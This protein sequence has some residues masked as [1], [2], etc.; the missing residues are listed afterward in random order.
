MSSI[1][2]NMIAPNP[3][4]GT[5]GPLEHAVRLK[6]ISAAKDHFAKHGYSKASVADIAR[7]AGFSKA[8]VYKFFDSKEAVGQALAAHI[9]VDYLGRAR[10]ASSRGP[11]AM[12]R[13]RLLL[14]EMIA[15]MRELCADGSRLYEIVF[16]S[17]EHR[18]APS[19]AYLGGLEEIARTIVMAGRT[20]GEFE[21]ITPVEEVARAIMASIEVYFNPVLLRYRLNEM[22][23]GANEVIDLLLR[24]L[25]RRN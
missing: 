14:L 15:C 18:W 4:K 17:M 11:T 3:L 12:E 10:A 13:M 24:S 22:P 21:D 7:H 19:L 8:Y 16:D 6:I 9:L 20:D 23:Q 5:R 25:A 1:T 2:F